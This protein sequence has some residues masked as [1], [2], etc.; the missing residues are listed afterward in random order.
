[1]RASSTATTSLTPA[2]QCA[3][4]ATASKVSTGNT[5]T[6]APNASP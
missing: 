1:M 5:G 6:E 3:S 4:S 2:R